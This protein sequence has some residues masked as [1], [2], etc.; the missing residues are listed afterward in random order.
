MTKVAA[1]P[2][3]LALR[4]TSPASQGIIPGR[5][6]WILPRS[7][8]RGT[9]KWWRGRSRIVSFP[10][11]SSLTREAASGRVTEMRTNQ[12]T[13]RN[14]R[15]LRRDMSLPEVLLWDC[16]RGGRLA[17]LRF[18]RQHPVG[19]YILDFYCASASLA[20]EVDGA[21]HDLPGQNHQDGRR[22]AWLMGQGIRTLR[23][24]A[25]DIL[26]DQALDGVLVT[27]AHA[28]GVQP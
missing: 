5:A 3:V 1:L 13:F 20:V 16:L 4:P 26:D 6:A 24:P 7:R 25:T 28:A 12:P 2:H 8:G 19:P 17:G 23:F 11:I 18:R 22:N 21:H 14:A 9:T 15:R 27:I 10:A